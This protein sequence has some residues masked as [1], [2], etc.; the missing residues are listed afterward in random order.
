MAPE[1]LMCHATT[2]ACGSPVSLT[3]PTTYLLLFY[4]QCLLSQN[5][6]LLSCDYLL[7]SYQLSTQCVFR[8]QS[9][10]DIHSES[11]GSGYLWPVD[12]GPPAIHLSA[13]RQLRCQSVP[14]P[15]LYNY[16]YFSSLGRFWCALISDNTDPPPTSINLVLQQFIPL[17]LTTPENVNDPIAV[18]LHIIL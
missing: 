8:H 9:S 12:G 2:T 17:D 13:S 4:A 16:R 10:Q 6:M 1:K 15:S 5:N 14:P 7:P 3:V 18:L 11:I